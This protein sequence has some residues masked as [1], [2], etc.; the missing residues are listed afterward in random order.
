MRFFVTYTKGLAI[1][2]Y[3]RPGKPIFCD[4]NCENLPSSYSQETHKIITH[5]SL[6]SNYIS[7][8]T[9]LYMLGVE[10]LDK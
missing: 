2:S 9:I 7:R 5:I 1:A 6:R 10:Y 4:Q 8:Q 3:T